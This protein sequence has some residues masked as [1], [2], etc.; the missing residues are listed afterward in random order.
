MTIEERMNRD[1]NPTSFY[2]MNRRNFEGAYIMPNTTPM[3]KKRRV[4]DYLASGRTL[5]PNQ[6]RSR[7]GVGNMRA[8]I[9]N[10]KSQVEAYGNWEVV[11]SPTA[12]GLTSY[13]MEF[14]GDQD[15]P[16]AVRAGIID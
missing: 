14:H 2:L 6:A 8:T 15:N 1:K 7:F 11:T 5:T 12:T 10:I 16:F 4:M 3:S 13:G 9:S